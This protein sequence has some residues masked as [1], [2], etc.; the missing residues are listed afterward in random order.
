MEIIRTHVSSQEDA[1]EADCCAEAVQAALKVLAYSP[2]A[3]NDDILAASQLDPD[4]PRHELLQARQAFWLLDQLLHRTR[5]ERDEAPDR[6]RLDKLEA[7]AEL[8]LAWIARH[9]VLG[10]G[11]RLHQLAATEGEGYATA[12]EAIDAVPEPEGSP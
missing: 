1:A 11:Y 3:N 5:A 2:P 4:D 9:S 10:R 7:L 8:G 6:Q 12:R